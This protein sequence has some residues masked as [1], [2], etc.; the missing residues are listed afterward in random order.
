MSLAWGDAIESTRFLE[1]KQLHERWRH[2]DSGPSGP[3]AGITLTG[4]DVFWLAAQALTGAGGD[5]HAAERRLRTA[6]HDALLRVSLDL[7]SLNLRS[8]VLSAADLQHAVLGRARL[9]N[10]IL[11]VAHLEGAFL[12]GAVLSGAFLD[13][14]YVQDAFLNGADLRRT[15]LYATDLSRASL[16]EA[17]LD[18]SILT[19]AVL[20][21]ANLNTAH[22]AR[23]DLT[24]ASLVGAS[25]RQADLTDATLY[26][27]RLEQVILT[28]A[29]LFRADLRRASFDTT[30]R[31]N[32]A[33][34][35]RVCLY[36]AGFDRTNLTVV[37]W[38]DVRC[39]GDE[40]T[41]S[42]DRETIV[43][44]SSDGPR[45]LK[46]GKKKQPKQREQEY[47]AA[48]R[49][50]RSLSVELQSQGVVRDAARFHFRAEVMSRRVQFHRSMRYLRSRWLLIAPLLFMPWLLSLL[51]SA[52]AGYGVYHVWRLA[53]TYL[54]V[55]A[56]F[57]CAY[58][59][60][61]QH[62]Q[63]GLQPVDALVLSLTSFHGRGLQPASALTDTM[64]HIA[65][66]EAILGLLIEGLFIAA[67]TRR[68]IGS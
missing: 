25:L 30:S 16:Q 1:L 52:V 57:A 21:G 51:L 49:A 27:V 20:D 5:I 33:E 66:L 50:Y 40:L 12:G 24:H 58:F 64:R 54:G 43:A 67:F 28:G 45:E 39:L 13:R 32:D 29:N 34:L 68:I 31:L 61:G 9:E 62:A 15:S 55:V 47:I 53:I 4:A 65:G 63:T 42:A 3:F 46:L 18:D 17:A 19:R 56:V 60:V 35:N 14:A 23:A 37:S 22:L 38:P 44:Y 36:Q 48:A 26:E 8:A 2:T 11:G 6:Q 7:S 59:V 10:V 41:A